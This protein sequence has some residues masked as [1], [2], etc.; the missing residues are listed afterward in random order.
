MGGG[1]EEREGRGKKERSQSKRNV[2]RQEDGENY[3]EEVLV[4]ALETR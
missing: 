3:L 1:E 2:W 4:W